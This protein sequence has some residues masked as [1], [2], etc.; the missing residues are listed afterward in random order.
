[1]LT[2]KKCENSVALSQHIGSIAV[3][4]NGYQANS[5]LISPEKLML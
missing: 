2:T 1:M 3:D 5:F 4:E